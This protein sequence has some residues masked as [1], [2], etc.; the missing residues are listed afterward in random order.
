MAK[1]FLMVKHIEFI[2]VVRRTKT[3]CIAVLVGII[4]IYACGLFVFNYNMKENFEIVNLISLIFLVMLVPFTFFLRYILFKKVNLSNFMNNYFNAHVI[5]L[6]ILD[7]GALFC[8]T[9]NLFVNGNFLYASIGLGV[10]LLGMFMLFPKEEDFE[11]IKNT[12]SVSS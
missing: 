8:I 6:A 4:A 10:S 2:V 9:T 1:D 3:L 7:F 12:N 11:K 5:P